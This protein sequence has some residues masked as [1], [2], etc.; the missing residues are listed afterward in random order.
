[1]QVLTHSDPPAHL[2]RAPPVT[3]TQSTEVSEFSAA[4]VMPLGT[5]TQTTCKKVLLP[6]SPWETDA[7]L[8]RKV[9][10]KNRERDDLTSQLRYEEAEKKLAVVTP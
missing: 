5:A 6:G 3:H 8:R 10:R 1:M 9:A 7:D 4:A 2:S